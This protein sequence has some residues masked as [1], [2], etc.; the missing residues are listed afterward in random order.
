MG[1]DWGYEKGLE[2]TY[3]LGRQIGR[4][5]SATVRVA[6]H[7]TSGAE[8][9]V[10]TLPKRLDSPGVSQYKKETHRQ[11]VKREVS[12]EIIRGGPFVSCQ[13]KR[14]PL[15][16]WQAHS[17]LQEPSLSLL[18]LVWQFAEM[19]GRVVQKLQ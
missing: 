17:F 6:Q 7:R 8:F 16:F 10:K 14:K 9:A 5:G 12:R 15:A 18:M 2:G 4:G 3:K 11:Y 1:D 13:P 19:I